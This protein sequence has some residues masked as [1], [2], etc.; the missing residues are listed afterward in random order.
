MHLK[1]AECYNSKSTNQDDIDRCC[2][3]HIAPAEAAN[4]ILDFEVNQMQ[5]RIERCA[6]MCGDEIW[7][8]YS[9]ESSKQGEAVMQECLAG[10][11][12]KHLQYM[13][14]VQSSIEKQLDDISKKH[15]N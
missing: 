1:L 12:E 9:K 3:K 11:G 13:K 8:K 2:Q 4:G 6:Q 5:S 14:S 15:Y 7:S 10:C